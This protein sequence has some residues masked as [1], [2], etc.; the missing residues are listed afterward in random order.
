MEFLE[1]IIRGPNLIEGLFLWII[2]PKITPYLKSERCSIFPHVVHAFR[3]PS[4]STCGSCTG[5]PV[6]LFF[7]AGIM[8]WYLFRQTGCPLQPSR[9]IYVFLVS[10]SFSVFDH[11]I[12][13]N[14]HIY[15]KILYNLVNVFSLTKKFAK[16]SITWEEV[17]FTKFINF[18]FL[19][20]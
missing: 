20:I 10:E 1:K 4:P 14:V 5:L 16:Y 9:L 12:F 11:S 19:C 8:K 6:A 18:Y 17:L 13:K 2:I 3:V 7:S 15:I